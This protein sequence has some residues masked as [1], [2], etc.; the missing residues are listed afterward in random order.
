MN[1]DVSSPRLFAIDS[2]AVL[3]RSYFAMI[4]NPLINA[5]GLNT[6]GIFGF[7][8]QLV[9]TIEGEHPEYLAVTADSRE[10][11]FRHKQFPQ[12]KATREK[13]PEDLVEQLP[14][15]PRIVEALRLPYLIKPGYEADDIIGTLMRQCQEKNIGGVMVTSDKDYM[16]LITDDIIMLNHKQ[17]YVG[18]QG[19]FD[20]FGCSPDQVIEFLGLMGDSSDNIPG[21]RGVG[22]KTAKRL[23]QEYGNIANIYDHLEE[24]KGKLKEKLAED[25]DNAFLSR[26]LVTIHRF[27]PMDT[28]FEDLHMPQNPLYNNSELNAILEELEFTSYLKKFNSNQTASISK[29]EDL[30]QSSKKLSYHIIE[31]LS[32]LENLINTIPPKTPLAFDIDYYESNI[33]DSHITGIAFC[34][35]P[36]QSSYLSIANF[37]EQKDALKTL[38]GKIFENELI[39]KV[40]FNLKKNIQLLSK[41]GIKISNLCSD[42]LIANHLADPVE[43]QQTLDNIIDHKLQTPRQYSFS[44]DNSTQLSMLGEDSS[45]HEFYF[46]ENA[47]A[48]LKLHH[49]FKSQ[50]IQA[51]M[52]PTYQNIEIPLLEVLATLELTGVAISVERLQEI[53]IE[54]EERLTDLSEEIYQLAGERFN[55]NSVVELQQIL[56]E[57]L[58]LHKTCNIKPKKIKLGNQMSTDETT[59]EKM[60]EFP[61]PRVLLQYRSLNKLKNTYIDQLPTFVNSSTRRIHSSFNQAATA[62]G[63]L[64]SDTPNLQNIPIRTKEGQRIR[65]VFIPSS[66]QHVLVSADYSQIELRIVAHYS[67]DPTFLE[68]YRTNKDIHALTAAAIFNVPVDAVTREMRSKAKEVNFGLIYRMGP[69]RLAL[70]TQSSK[71]EAKVFIKKYFQKYDTIHTLQEQFIENARREGYTLTLMG[72][73]RYL[74]NINGKGFAKRLDEGAAV[75]TPIQGSAA[76]IIKMAMI[77]IHRRMQKESFRSRMILTVHDELVFDA[78]KDEVELLKQVIREEMENVVTLEVPLITEIGVGENWLEAH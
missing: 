56:Y 16:Q 74:P 44:T 68:A 1:Q 14:Y 51:G 3:Y 6:S 52:W 73:R 27:V 65:R 17:E 48:I 59:L 49:L 37:K 5:N 29:N 26:E 28:D 7:F 4:R 62:T 32:Q 45:N 21:V 40:G 23:I 10:P 24:V 34:T 12:Y 53:A 43:K 18:K 47:D 72:R 30:P 71:S 54:F 25:R 20:K 75:N 11:T 8:T 41:E 77:A 76:E 55:I 35:K 69:D 36:T 15:L 78:L 67:K 33:I 22:E 9:R 63:R 66:P 70:V 42:I 57:K 2:M 39:P 19:V 58:Q 50:L 60:H 31:E 61:L 64:S 13:M 46:C 38:L